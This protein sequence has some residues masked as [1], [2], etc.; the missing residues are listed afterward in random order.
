MFALVLLP[1]DRYNPQ[2]F[3][4]ARIEAPRVINAD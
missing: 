2:D 1:L 3:T 4:D